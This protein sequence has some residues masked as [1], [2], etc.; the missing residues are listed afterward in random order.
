MGNRK[1]NKNDRKRKKEDTLNEKIISRYGDLSKPGALSNPKQMSR[2]YDKTPKSIANA[3]KREPAYYL[4]RKVAKNFQRRRV[5]VSQPNYQLAIDLKDVREY[6]KKNKNVSYLFCAI[7]CFSRF[8]YCQ[9][10]TNKKAES[11]EKALITILD[12]MEKPCRLIH[13]DRGSEFFNVRIQKLLKSRDIKLFATWNYDIK[14]SLVE[15]WQR[16]LMRMINKYMEKNNTESYID[17]LQD[18]VRN[19]NSSYHTAIRMPPNM[20]S[21]EN[22]GEVM[23]NLY[24][25]GY[26]TTKLKK[27][28]Q[29]EPL[30]KQGDTVVVSRLKGQFDKEYRG[31]FKPEIYFVHALA[32]RNPPTYKVLILS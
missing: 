10:M 16:T 17:A 4:Y 2:H 3:L 5:I 7:D 26:S 24:N 30:F 20:V 29:N 14:S 31:T 1:N 9:P 6:K 8:A 13:A 28:S 11:A 19:Y 22:M 15:R 25:K 27:K 32:S 23:D 18:I 21:D 12:E